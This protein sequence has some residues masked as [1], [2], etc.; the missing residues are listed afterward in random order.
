[1]TSLYDQVSWKKWGAK[2]FKH[3]LDDERNAAFRKHYEEICEECPGAQHALREAMTEPFEIIDNIVDEWE[4]ED[5]D[6]R[7]VLHAL[8]AWA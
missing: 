5:G 6:V 1:M 7:F 3:W 2:K 8:P 4:F